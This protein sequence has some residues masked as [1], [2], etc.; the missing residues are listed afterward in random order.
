[1]VSQLKKI[2]HA[3]RRFRNRRDTL[4]TIGLELI[5]EAEMHESFM[6]LT[7]DVRNDYFSFTRRVATYD[8]MCIR[9]RLPCLREIEI[10]TQSPID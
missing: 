7:D 1:M 9:L 5:K 4:F 6:M 3:W 8:A 10:L 2:N